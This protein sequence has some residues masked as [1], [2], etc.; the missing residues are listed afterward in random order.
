M[1]VTM[2]MVRP[3]CWVKNANLWLGTDIFR[4]FMYSHWTVNELVRCLQNDSEEWQRGRQAEGRHIEP[5]V[6]FDERRCI[7]IC[8]GLVEC[9]TL[10]WKMNSQLSAMPF[11]DNFISRTAGAILPKWL[12][13]F[14][15]GRKCDFPS[16]RWW[17]IDKS[18]Y[19]AENH[20]QR[21]DDS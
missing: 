17:L 9:D 5:N 4:I 18:K 14:W 11:I 7:L 10:R 1:T 8:F 13:S 2:W 20:F 16:K 6:V 21:S 15:S 3:R 12:R 19:A